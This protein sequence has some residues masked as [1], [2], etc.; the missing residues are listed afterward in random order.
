MAGYDELMLAAVGGRPPSDVELSRLPVP[1]GCSPE[2]FRVGVLSAV[3]R[4]LE[5]RGVRARRLASEACKRHRMSWGAEGPP[6]H[7]GGDCS[8]CGT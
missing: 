7:A 8:G 1:P 5:V 4:I 2:V 6:R 3:Q